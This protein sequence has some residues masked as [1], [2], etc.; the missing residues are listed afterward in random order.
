[1]PAVGLAAAPAT[2]W[3]P[4][5]TLALRPWAPGPRS[6][7]MRS[8]SPGAQVAAPPA[9]DREPNGP[10]A[11]AH[12]SAVTGGYTFLRIFPT[13]TVCSKFVCLQALSTQ[14]HGEARA[15]LKGKRNFNSMSSCRHVNK[16]KT[17]QM[18][19]LVCA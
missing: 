12:G 10:Q 16:E 14:G 17:Q 18:G 7:S 1:M 4:P 2:C 6:V 13:S 3:G 15:K 19:H 9:L 5:C 11:N 8:R